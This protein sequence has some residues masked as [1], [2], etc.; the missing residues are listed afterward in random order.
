MRAS[1][2]ASIRRIRTRIGWPMAFGSRICPSSSIVDERQFAYPLISLGK[3]HRQSNV[4][5]RVLEF[6][7]SDAHYS[8][9][10]VTENR[11]THGASSSLRRISGSDRPDS[12][13]TGEAVRDVLTRSPLSLSR[14]FDR[15]I[16]KAP[17]DP[18]RS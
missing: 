5:P 14:A 12:Q 18:L 8:A 9:D 15:R 4:G 11:G 16:V 7:R 2:R 6:P 17:M 10:A 3:S 13:S 1:F